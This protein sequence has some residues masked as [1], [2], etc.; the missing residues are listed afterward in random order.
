M[1]PELP[2]RCILHQRTSE[3]LPSQR[4][5]CKVCQSNFI[6]LGLILCHQSRYLAQQWTVDHISRASLLLC[7]FVSQLTEH[8]GGK[9]E[10]V[11]KHN[12]Q[13]ESIEASDQL[14]ED[15]SVRALLQTYRTKR[16]LVLLIDDK[17]RLF[18]F[19]LSAKGCT[20]VVLGWYHI[21]HAWGRI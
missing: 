10:S 16:P 8:R 1:V 18:P 14:E 21:A 12:G 2:G 4:V 15:K 19:D 13:L 20:Y 5:L 11:H 3:G 17:Y 6:S 7:A 9:A